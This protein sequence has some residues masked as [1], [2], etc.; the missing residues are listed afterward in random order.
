[1]SQSESDTAAIER[2]TY[3]FRNAAIAG[4]VVCPLV[5]LLPP[6]RLDL[7]NTFL[8][9]VFFMSTNHITHVYTGESIL[10]RFSNRVSSM[11]PTGLPAK[12]QRTSELI[13][14]AREREA[15]Q[16]GIQNQYARPEDQTIADSAKKVWLG[17]ESEDWGKKRN[18]EHQK[19]L[20]EGKGISDIILE[21]IGDVF[22]GNWRGKAKEEAQ[23]EDSTTPKKP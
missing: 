4:A 2:R 19:A 5:M 11:A 10:Q 6:R 23:P 8:A 7:R 18:A 14:E 12:A 13:K 20:E 17:G 15:A 16:K 9:G 22:S 21:Q 1:M 3:A